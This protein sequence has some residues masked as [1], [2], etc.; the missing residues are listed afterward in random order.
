LSITRQ[1]ARNI[2]INAEGLSKLTEEAEK[3]FAIKEA[4]VYE[5]F[6]KNYVS[7]KLREIALLGG[8]AFEFQAF[9]TGVSHNKE[10]GMIEG[11]RFFWRRFLKWAEATH[12]LMPSIRRTETTLM[13]SFSWK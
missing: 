9:E 12:E 5:S 13:I 6:Y 8:R 3:Y 2:E 10:I 4:L 7:P 11:D 1:A